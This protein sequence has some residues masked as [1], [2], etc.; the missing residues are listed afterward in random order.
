VARENENGRLGTFETKFTIPDLAA[1]QAWL[2]TSSVVWGTQRVPLQQRVGA[3]D[4]KDKSNKGNPLVRNGAKLIPSVTRVVREGGELFVLFEVY[5]PGS[6]PAQ[7]LD[8]E[9]S[10]SLFNRKGK[11]LESEAVVIDSRPSEKSPSVPVQLRV[12]LE[13]LPPGDYLCQVSVV[14]KAGKKFAFHRT[15]MVILPAQAGL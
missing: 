15:P 12:P 6:T 10:V 11:A 5:E 3:A 2:R 4:K 7:T 1:E 8:L 9:A 14:D 13:N